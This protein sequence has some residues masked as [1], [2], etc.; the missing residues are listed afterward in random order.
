MS[1][2]S[3][4]ITITSAAI[5]GPTTVALGYSNGS[6]NIDEVEG[7]GAATVSYVLDAALASAGW[8]IVGLVPVTSPAPADI[9]W[10]VTT[11]AGGNTLVINDAA[12]AADALDFLIQLLQG[13]QVYASADP[14][15]TNEPD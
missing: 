5:T 6:G 7:Q 10:S 15:I 14:I 9:T 4:T 2:T 1:N 11:S 12:T 3:T 13:G 8:S